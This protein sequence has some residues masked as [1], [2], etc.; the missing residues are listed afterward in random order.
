MTCIVGIVKKEKVFMAAD[1]AGVG[2]YDVTIRLDPKIFKVDDFLIGCTTS[3][4]MIQLL[5]FS[6][7]PPKMH[8]D[9]DIYE[10]MCTDFVNRMRD[11]FKTGGFTTIKDSVENG[12]TFLVGYKNRLFTIHDDFQVGESSDRFDAVGCGTP[13]ALGVMAAL[14]NTDIEPE[15]LLNR[16][17]EITT[18]FSAGVR[19]PFILKTSTE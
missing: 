8:P 3:F 1:S 17:L 7:N 4:R 2:G 16:A 9:T 10:Y 18:H 12:G 11:C 5:R 19:P 15:L 6:F 14:H 13:Y